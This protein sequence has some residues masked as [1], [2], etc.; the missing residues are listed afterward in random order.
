M[1]ST[2]GKTSTNLRYLSLMVL[3]IQNTVLILL[4]RASRSRTDGQTGSL[5][6]ASTVVVLIE[7]VK[8]ATCLLLECRRLR[9]AQVFPSLRVLSTILRECAQTDAL[10][11]II[12]SG[13]YAIQN[14]LLFV[15]LS[16]LDALTYQITYQLKILTTALFSVLLLKRKLSWI[17]WLSLCILISG[18]V[19]VQ[20]KAVVSSD[21]S[22]T[23][24]SSGKHMH[25]MHTPIYIILCLCS[26]TIPS[27]WPWSHPVCFAQLGSIRG[28]L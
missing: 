1:V 14:N 20:Y 16:H 26:R 17:K 23:T 5:Y 13:L 28:L 21:P 2:S 25:G 12:P 18:V 11:M 8:I 7:L 24:Y 4:M 19:L 9:P 22:K 3:V 6:I 15:A 10:H 27:D